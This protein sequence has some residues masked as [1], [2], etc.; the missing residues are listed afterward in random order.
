[1]KVEEKDYYTIGQVVEKLKSLFSDVTISKV[2]FLEEEGLIKPERTASGYRK[3]SEG[4]VKRLTSILNLQKEQYLPL[5][6]I[7][8]N[9]QLIER[10]VNTSAAKIKDID[11]GLPK[12]LKEVSVK[13]AVKKIGLNKKQLQ[14]LKGYSIVNLDDANEVV[15]ELD[16]EILNIVKSLSKFGVEPRHL[17]MFENSADNEA[18]LI[19]QIVAPHAK[20]KRRFEEKATELVNIFQNLKSILLKRSLIQLI[21]KK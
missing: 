6:V 12:E 8:R 21:D 9:M 11:E 2:R 3:F 10:G 18:M 7:K 19:Y 13:E 17:R 15:S 16:V 1:L 14:E 4:D 20:N 5:S